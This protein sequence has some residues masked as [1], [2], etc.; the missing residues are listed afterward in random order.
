M[1][2][3]KEALRFFENTKVYVK[4]KSKEIQKKLFSLGF[5]WGGGSVKP[6]YFEDPFIFIFGDELF[7]GN[8]VERFNN[9]RNIEIT[10]ED[11]LNF[12]ESVS[13]IIIDPQYRPFKNMEECIEEMKKHQPFG[14]VKRISNGSHTSILYIDNWNYEFGVKIHDD[15]T[16]YEFKS[17]INLYTFLDGTPFGIK[18]E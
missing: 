14:W 11:I 15:P 3:K 18:K 7:R 17:F 9:S 8:D 5:H 6:N 13:N 2:V 16:F 12:N 4:D 1:K 10:P